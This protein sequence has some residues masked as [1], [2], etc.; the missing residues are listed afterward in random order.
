MH[1]ALCLSLIHLN[2]H[3]LRILA[4]IILVAVLIWFCLPRALR[5]K[6]WEGWKKFGHALGNF[7]AR[8]LLTVI[9]AVL[10]MPFGLLVRFFADSL[11]SKKRP[12]RWFDHPPVA[13]DLNE[14]RRQ[15]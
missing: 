14:A 8:V 6:L 7:Q 9:Y 11:H 12:E 3:R 4:A 5:T 2:A 15:G 13:N 1:A 10:I